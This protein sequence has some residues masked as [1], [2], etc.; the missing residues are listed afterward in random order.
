MAPGPPPQPCGDALCGA[1]RGNPQPGEC[2]RVKERWSPSPGDDEDPPLPPPD[3]PPCAPGPCTPIVLDLSGNGFQFT[4]AECGVDF[5]I[6]RVDRLVRLA[7]TERWRDDVFLALDRDDNGWIT[8]GGE[9]FGNF[10]EQPKSSEPN[11]YNALA[12]FDS[13]GFGGNGDS[14]IDGYDE[15]YG[16]LLLWHDS[17]HNGTSEARELYTLEEAGVDAIYLDY[18]RSHEQDE[19]GNELRYFGRVCLSGRPDTLASWMTAQGPLNCE[20][21]VQSV[22]DPM[23][24]RDGNGPGAVIDTDCDGWVGQS[25]DVFFV[26]DGWSDSR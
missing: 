1:P 10:T 17:N 18:W 9:L 20:C 13:P 21:N 7:W 26:S 12:L 2:D 16:V 22:L 8:D 23:G 11:G 19:H 3:P 25:T 6:M 24:L 15:V 5:D 14:K 4:N